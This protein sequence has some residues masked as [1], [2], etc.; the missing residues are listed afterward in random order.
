[1]RFIE[2]DHM[3]DAALNS[4]PKHLFVD[5][6]ERQHRDGPF[7]SISR[8]TENLLFETLECLAVPKAI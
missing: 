6:V 8:L 3:R 2:D 5:V 4:A 1:M 7:D